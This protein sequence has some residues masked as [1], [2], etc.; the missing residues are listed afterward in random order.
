MKT[1]KVT[2]PRVLK[3]SSRQTGTSVT[4]IDRKKTAMAPGKRISKSGTVYYEYR[5]N[6]TDLRTSKN[7]KK[8][9]RKALTQKSKK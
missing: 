7:P 1:K 3:G 4:K 6:R 2:R 8:A 5:T 9:K